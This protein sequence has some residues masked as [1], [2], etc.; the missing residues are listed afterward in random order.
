MMSFLVEGYDPEAKSRAHALVDRLRHGVPD[1]V[2]WPD[3]EGVELGNIRGTWNEVLLALA[4]YDA[5][6]DTEA[7]D[8]FLVEEDGL[9]GIVISGVD[10][11]PAILTEPEDYLPHVVSIIGGKNSDPA[12]IATTVGRLIAKGIGA[13]PKLLR[14][15]TASV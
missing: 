3:G 11:A 10:H 12:T 5:L 4:R 1:D 6:D 2:V 7:T 14:R 9:V 8:I 15:S 13:E